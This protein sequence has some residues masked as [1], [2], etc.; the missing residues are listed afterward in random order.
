DGDIL[1]FQGPAPVK[2]R[3]GKSDQV[4]ALEQELR[5]GLGTKSE[6]RRTAQGRGR[7]VVHF[8]NVD[9][10]ERLYE[11]LMG[12]GDSSRDAEAA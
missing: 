3:R 7:I 6:I 10:F 11:H 4:V 12:R 2:P 1:P 5:R 9:E 8:S